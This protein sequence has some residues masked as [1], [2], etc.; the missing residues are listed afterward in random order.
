MSKQVFCI[1]FLIV[2]LSVCIPLYKAVNPHCIKIYIIYCSVV[3]ILWILLI[4]GT[5]ICS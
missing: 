1:V 5:N 2:L 4:F 3:S